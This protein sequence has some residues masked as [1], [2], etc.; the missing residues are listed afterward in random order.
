L[1]SHS[2][3]AHVGTHSTMVSVLTRIR[4]TVDELLD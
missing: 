1:F 3:D 2:Y 4:V